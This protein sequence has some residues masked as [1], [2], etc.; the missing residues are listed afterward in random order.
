MAKDKTNPVFP[1]FV[2]YLPNGTEDDTPIAAIVVAQK[3]GN[4]CVL[5]TIRPETSGLFP[6]DGL[7]RHVDDPDFDESPSQRSE[8]GAWREAQ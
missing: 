5:A 4:L 3:P 8:Y 7:I 6:V 2:Q 1:R